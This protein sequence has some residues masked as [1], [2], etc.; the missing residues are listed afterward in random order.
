VGAVRVYPHKTIRREGE[1]RIELLQD[2]SEACLSYLQKQRMRQLLPLPNSTGPGAKNRNAAR[3][4]YGLLRKLPTECDSTE[5][6]RAVASD[7]A[8]LPGA[9][10]PAG[11]RGRDGLRPMDPARA[12][13]CG[14]RNAVYGASLGGARGAGC[15]GGVR[16][17][18]RVGLRQQGESRPTGRGIEVAGVLVGPHRVCRGF[19]YSC[20]FQPIIAFPF[21]SSTACSDQQ[22][23][24]GGKAAV[25]PSQ[26]HLI[27]QRTFV[28]GSGIRRTDSRT[29]PSP[30][31]IMACVGS[32]SAAPDVHTRAAHEIHCRLAIS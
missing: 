1:I 12:G 11:F 19:T 23:A 32:T 10:E 30:S 24:A 5:N 15:G 14:E 20:P 2:D 13:R 17:F 9:V 18:S 16:D 6:G 29:P 28:D 26:H 25:V 8:R 4:M 27:F 7:P 31:G 22:R 3:I 21:T